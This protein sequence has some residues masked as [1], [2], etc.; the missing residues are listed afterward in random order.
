[1]NLNYTLSEGVVISTEVDDS[2]IEQFLKYFK[3]LKSYLESKNL[4][5]NGH[6]ELSSK[7]K[8]KCLNSKEPAT[9]KQINLLQKRGI[10]FDDNI[11]KGEASR[12]IDASFGAGE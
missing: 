3:D 5:P 4:L 6:R 10:A 8:A 9:E 12:L 1:M 7:A 11:T 2:N